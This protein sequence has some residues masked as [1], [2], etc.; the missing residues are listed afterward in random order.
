MDRCTVCG[1][2]LKN[3]RWREIGMGPVCFK[4]RQ[5][6]PQEPNEPGTLPFDG[7]HFV[8]R[9]DASGQA[10]TNVPHHIVLHSPAGLEF[11]YGG[12]GPADTAL[13]LLALVTDR[14]TAERLHQDFKWDF[15]A[16]LPREGGTIT[17]QQVVTWL[18]ERGVTAA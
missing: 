7:E 10:L 9:R 6:T 5:A 2:A 15:I 12:S 8:F 18:A 13:N 17:R 1:R 4:R 16:R 14:Q 11:G 3:P